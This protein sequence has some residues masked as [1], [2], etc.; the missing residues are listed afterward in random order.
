MILKKIRK[1]RTMM[2]SEDKKNHDQ[3]FLKEPRTD[4]SGFLV[5]HQPIFEIFHPLT[6]NRNLICRLKIKLNFIIR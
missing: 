6:A 1:W 2:V 5:A 3:L 4:D